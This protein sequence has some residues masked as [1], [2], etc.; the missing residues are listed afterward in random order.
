M[1]ENIPPP[2]TTVALGEEHAFAQRHPEPLSA[3]TDSLDS[4]SS[5]KENSV[6]VSKRSAQQSVSSSLKTDNGG[7]NS[8][9]HAAPDCNERQ[10]ALPR[11]DSDMDAASATRTASL[12]RNESDPS[13]TEQAIAEDHSP[14]I[15]TTPLDAQVDRILEP[16]S[17]EEDSDGNIPERYHPESV[18]SIDPPCYNDESG[19]AVNA[20]I[21]D[22][23][24][25]QQQIDLD[26]DVIVEVQIEEED[27]DTLA[28]ELE[29]EAVQAVLENNGVEEV[30]LD[31]SAATV[32][33]L[34]ELEESSS[35]PSM[36]KLSPPPIPIRSA[37]TDRFHSDSTDMTNRELVALE[38]ADFKCQTRDDIVRATPSPVRSSTAAAASS[39]SEQSDSQIPVASAVLVPEEPE[40]GTRNNLEASL[41]PS[42]G[43]RLGSSGRSDGSPTGLV[44]EETK[45]ERNFWITAIAIALCLNSILVGGIVVAGF[46]LAGRCRS[47]PSSAQATTSF[48]SPTVSPIDANRMSRTMSPTAAPGPDAF[49]SMAFPPNLADGTFV[50]PVPAPPT[51]SPYP[52]LPVMAN[53]QTGTIA[54]VP[55]P[56]FSVDAS[57][58][59]TIEELPPES[60]PG[61][62]FATPPPPEEEIDTSDSDFGGSLG[63]PPDTTD[64]T[65][66]DEEDDIWNEEPGGV[67]FLT[68][69][70]VGSVAE[71]FICSGLCL[72]YRRVKRKRNDAAM[73]EQ[74][75]EHAVNGSS[76]PEDLI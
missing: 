28:R 22:E 73:A 17:N 21:D 58:G 37:L 54:A 48:F 68:L 63:L 15:T 34:T 66:V 38:R 64:E 16:S 69:F 47:A 27:L 11:F 18:D 59:T 44:S 25:P 10:S 40:G 72:Y 36:E 55:P 76:S 8:V 6:A 1:A 62:I 74:G 5:E 50:V 32:S 71:F 30:R 39:G 43:G 20:E 75:P 65:I 61:R 3:S 42:S 70:A 31:T 46:C 33:G 56:A 52:T 19:G 9:A 53:V 24:A 67:P 14:P 60:S 23:L 2:Q 7:D 13:P 29:P 45:Q 57:S 35:S 4:E 41:V 51:I 26:E 12:I 49:P